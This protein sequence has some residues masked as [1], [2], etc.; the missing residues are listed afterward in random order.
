MG[1]EDDVELASLPAPKRGNSL[2]NLKQKRTRVND[3]RKTRPSKGLIQF[4]LKV[5]KRTR[6]IFEEHYRAAFAATS[7]RLTRGEFLGRILAGNA[8]AKADLM[9][10][11]G[12]PEISLGDQ[13]AGRTERL[14]ARVKP[15]VMEY[16][17]RHLQR[18]RHWT[19]ADAIEGVCAKSQE[20]EDARDELERME[21]AL[22][23]PCPHCGKVRES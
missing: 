8:F 20:F 2:G 3:G 10:A 15:D 11:T 7:G 12:Q 16:L 22:R 19:L 5:P 17:E 1:R 18:H 9:A 4:N 14:S 13:E 21:Q 6:D 23:E